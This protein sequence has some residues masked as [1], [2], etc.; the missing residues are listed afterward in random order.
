MKIK[1][2][3]GTHNQVYTA[4]IGIRQAVFVTEQGISAQL[5]F[6]GQ[7]DQVTHYVATSMISRL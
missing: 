2:A 7:D 3:L 6:D 1:S 4:A 5:E